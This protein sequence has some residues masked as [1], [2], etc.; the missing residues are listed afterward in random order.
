LCLPDFLAAVEKNACFQRLA[1]K[2]SAWFPRLMPAGSKR[3]HEF[4]RQVLVTTASPATPSHNLETFR[5]LRDRLRQTL[6][7]IFGHV[8]IDALFERSVA[9]A[10]DDFVWLPDAM[11]ARGTNASEVSIPSATTADTLLDGFAAV[12]AYDIGL[13]IEFVGEDLILPLVQKAW[14]PI[15]RLPANGE[16]D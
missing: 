14:G 10:T 11:G 4:T 16:S 9:L 6:V 12:M 7:P 8:A 2:T 5:A 1:G 3:Y 15:G 13:L